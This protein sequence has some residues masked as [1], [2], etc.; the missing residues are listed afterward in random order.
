MKALTAILLSLMAIFP[1][2]ANAHNTNY[3]HNHHNYNHHHHGH[4][5]T[6]EDV[7]YMQ[8]R[9]ESIPCI[10][11]EVKEKLTPAPIIE[12]EKPIYIQDQNTGHTIKVCDHGR[13]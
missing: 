5:A 1:T 7:F 8:I 10:W 4:H 2:I 9:S 13:E 12:C 6:I 3:W 11:C